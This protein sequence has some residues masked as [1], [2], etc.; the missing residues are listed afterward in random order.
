MAL[1]ELFNQTLLTSLDDNIRFGAGFPSQTGANNVRKS[2]LFGLIAEYL[3]RSEGGVSVD[4]GNNTIDFSSTFGT[5][6]YSLI[7]YDIG[8]AGVEVTAQTATGF[9]VNCLSAGNI[10]YIAIKNI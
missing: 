1:K 9:T 10:N 5:T 8:G 6:D 2:V 7:V 4:Q 3:I